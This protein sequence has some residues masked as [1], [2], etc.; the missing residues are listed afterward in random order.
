MSRDDPVLPGPVRCLP[1]AFAVVSTLG[2]SM[3][4]HLP[5]PAPGL[6][7]AVVVAAPLAVCL[8]GV[9]TWRGQPLSGTRLCAVAVLSWVVFSVARLALVD[10]AAARLIGSPFALLDIGLVWVGS[11]AVIGAVVYRIDWPAVDPDI[12]DQ[13]SQP[14]PADD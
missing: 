4:N 5:V 13:R 7:A 8:T 6:P 10:P 1:G 2:V 9:A 11:Y 12:P 14:D 3:A